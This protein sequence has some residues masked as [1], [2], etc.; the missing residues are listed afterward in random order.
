M[1]WH[2]QQIEK[3]THTH[4]IQPTQETHNTHKEVERHTLA[5]PSS[6]GVGCLPRP[7]MPDSSALRGEG[8]LFFAAAAA[9]VVVCLRGL[10]RVLP[11]PVGSIAVFPAASASSSPS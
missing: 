5:G 11:T 10:V 7:R 2:V 4:T 6:G 8:P 9:V 3:R 1:H